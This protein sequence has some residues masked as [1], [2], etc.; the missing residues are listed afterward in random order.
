VPRPLSAC[1]LL[2]IVAVAA[3]A[4]AQ[5]TRIAE[6]PTDGVYLPATPLAGDQD[7]RATSVN[8][9]GLQF[10]GGLAITLA[11]TVGQ[12]DET[13]SAGP[14]VGLFVAGATGGGVLPPVGIGFGVEWLRPSRTRLAPDPGTPT[15][16]TVASSLPLGRRASVGFGWHHFS[17]DSGELDGLDTWDMGLTWRVGNRAAVGAVIRDLWAPRVG[18]VPVQRR[19]E[20]E[21]TGRPTGTDRLDLGVGGRIGERRADVDAW[22]RGSVKVARG[23]GLHA[24]FESRALSVIDTFPSG[25]IA[26]RDERDLRAT[27]GVEISFGAVGIASYG[28]YAASWL[29]GDDLGA[30]VGGTFLARVSSQEV[31]GVFGRRARIERIELSGGIGARGMTRLSLRLREIARDPA[32]RAVVLSIDGIDAGWATVQELRT[33][34]ERVRAAGKKVYA[35]MVAGSTRDYFVASAADKIYVD[36][37]GGLRLTGFAGTTLYFRGTFDKLGVSA[38]FEKIAEFKS[39]PESYT[40]LGPSAPALRMR[41][42]MYDSMF[43]ELVV[44]IARGRRLERDAVIALIEGGPYSAGDLADDRRLVDAVA[45]PDKVAELIEVDLGGMYPVAEAPD[46]KPDRWELPAVAVI[47]ADGD[48][49]DGKSQTIPILNRKLVGGDTIAEAIK[50]ARGDSRVKAIV[51]RINSPGGS[52]L[53][54][55]LMSREV[56]KTRGN[57]PIICSMGDVAASG[58][59]FLAAGCDKV[60]AE[61]MTITGSIGIFTGKF[62]LSGLLSKLGVTSVTV[63]RGGR[64]DMD[65]YYRPYTD[66]ERALIRDKLEYLYGRFT[67]TVAE[68][69]GMTEKEVDAIGR[70]RVWTGSQAKAVNLVDELGGLGDAIEYAKR[71][72]GLA[73]DDRVR[74]VEMPKVSGGILSWILGGVARVRA[75]DDGTRVDLTELGPV[76]A[77]LRALPPSLLVDP[78]AVQAR[79]P[80]EIVWE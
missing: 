38:Q 63:T 8:P 68:G 19:Y 21:L 64:A 24:A 23:F 44:G 67:G 6:E 60:F 78:E 72:A 55:E 74:I 31:P 39:A 9:A 33:E 40:D 35:Y 58:G 62:D 13:T 54:S 16:Y 49:V 65:G 5:T 48:I 36:P 75:A 47:Y 17:D 26:F 46:E 51:I 12:E 10:V 14:G 76:K 42:E 37:A 15:R 69:R 32:V 70:G 77:V 34:I 28:T 1:A 73:V 4:A 25:D 80:F 79:M 22:L 43:E 53:A 52:A 11:A 71:Q 7:A 20:L 3:P 18:T 45:K 2:A 27:L 50:A 66:E 57:K 30:G 29:D 41:D 59:Y 61:P 56:F